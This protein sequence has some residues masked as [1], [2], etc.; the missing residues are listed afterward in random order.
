M[1]GG[2]GGVGRSEDWRD[3]ELAHNSSPSGFQ[4]WAFV[5]WLRNCPKPSQR[6]VVQENPGFLGLRIETS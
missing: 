5:R 4:A 3:Y 6:G 2:I 1:E